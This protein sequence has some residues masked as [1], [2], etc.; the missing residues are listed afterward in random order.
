[1]ASLKTT[2]ALLVILMV[3]LGICAWQG[4]LPQ[5]AAVVAVPEASA[6]PPS[7]SAAQHSAT[8]T[9]PRRS[10]KSLE[11]AV[12]HL[13][14]IK[15]AEEQRLYDLKLYHALREDVRNGFFHR[16][17][18]TSQSNITA[19]DLVAIREREF[20]LARKRFY[21]LEDY[22]LNTDFTALTEEEKDKVFQFYELRKRIEDARDHYFDIP[23]EEWVALSR[24]NGELRDEF[25]FLIQRQMW[26]DSQQISLG[27]ALR[28]YCPHIGEGSFSIG[29]ISI[30]GFFPSVW[31]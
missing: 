10:R 30:R 7:S 5:S 1:M 6:A 25:S 4:H 13:N 2:I 22:V 14:T 8:L 31:L 28:N 3:S 19:Q 15:T 21:A 20:Q 9:A 29:G 23:V 27:N 17:F 26:H 18:A 12:F 24:E 11:R 16:C